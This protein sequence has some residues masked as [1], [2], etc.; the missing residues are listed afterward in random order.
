[1]DNSITTIFLDLD[2]TVYDRF[3]GIFDQISKKIYDYI[4]EYLNVPAEEIQHLMEHYFHEYGSTLYGLQQDYDIDEEE[5]LD[6]TYDLDLNKYLKP[7][8][9]LRETLQ[10]IPQ[11]KWIFTNSNYEHSKRVLKILEIDDL[12]V[13]IL[14]V[15]AMEFVPKPNP[16]VYHHALEMAGDPDPIN[17]VF[18]DDTPANLAPARHMG[19]TTI[20]MG[21]GLKP[22]HAN[23]SLENLYRLPHVLQEIED[24][25]AVSSLFMQTGKMEQMPA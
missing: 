21:S 10:S 19:F 5:Y 2:G 1:M 14:D 16:W 17:C 22:A 15:W 24:A 4:K 11:P 6:Y 3:N 8:P 23:Y 25:H 13:D 12:F 20:W 18:I 7:D 9:R